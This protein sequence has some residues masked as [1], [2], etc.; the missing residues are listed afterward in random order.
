MTTGG[1]RFGGREIER[2][3]ESERERGR[4][5]REGREREGG[6]RETEEDDQREKRREGIFLPESR[7]DSRQS[8]RTSKKITRGDTTTK[9]NHD[10]GADRLARWTL[11]TKTAPTTWTRARTRT[12]VMTRTPH[13][14]YTHKNTH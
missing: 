5:E 7:Y 9:D 11:V 12:T 2:R 4:G 14:F 8:G 1:S 3:K 13:D 10:V 6:T